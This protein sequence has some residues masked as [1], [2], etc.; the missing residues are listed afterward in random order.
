MELL[1]V[2]S[3]TREIRDIGEDEVTR[4]FKFGDST[5]STPDWDKLVYQR[6]LRSVDQDLSL[7]AHL[8]TD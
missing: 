7:K 8:H 1:A 2:H 5:G 4:Y 3:E 6:I